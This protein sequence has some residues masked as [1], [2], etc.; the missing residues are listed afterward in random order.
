MNA[1]QQTKKNNGFTI[2][3]VVLVLAIAGLIFLMVFIALPALQR[4]QRDTQRRDDASTFVSQLTSY[5][6]NFKGKLPAAANVES[7]A[8]NYLKWNAGQTGEFND[9][10]TGNGYN[11]VDSNDKLVN[12]GDVYYGGPKS[13]C[14]GDQVKVVSTGNTRQAAVAF[15]LEGSGVFCQSNI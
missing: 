12:G 1:Q 9:P 13:L 6:T 3:E 10:T 2:I 5:S 4:N 7:F 8:T 15:K 14:D 11:F